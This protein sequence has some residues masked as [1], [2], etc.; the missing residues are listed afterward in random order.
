MNIDFKGFS[1]HSVMKRAGLDESTYYRIKKDESKEP[2]QSTIEKIEKAI[3]EMDEERNKYSISPESLKAMKIKMV[4]YRVRTGISQKEL[5]SLCGVSATTYHRFRD[6]G[7][8][9][10][11]TY[12]RIV[13][14]LENEKND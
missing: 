9:S 7:Y 13:D 8:I 1:V 10:F 4:E 2:R 5:L 11:K 3:Q 6:S 14:F 12:K